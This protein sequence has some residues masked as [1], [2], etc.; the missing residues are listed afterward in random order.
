MRFFSNANHTPWKHT[1]KWCALVRDVPHIMQG[2]RRC[3]GATSVTLHEL[4]EYSQNSGRHSQNMKKGCTW[5]PP[6]DTGTANLLRVYTPYTRT[7]WVISHHLQF[8]LLANLAEPIHHV[9]SML[10][11]NTR[12]TTRRKTINGARWN[13]Q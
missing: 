9:S 11:H 8:Q 5:G 13:S 4:Y 12:R 3:S 2:F 10:V 7:A 6:L 1:Q